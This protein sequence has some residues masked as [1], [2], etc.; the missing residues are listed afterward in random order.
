MRT[1]GYIAKSAES[2]VVGR[3]GDLRVAIL[4]ERGLVT[5]GVEV[6]GGDGAIFWIRWERRGVAEGESIICIIA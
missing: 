4:E 1:V 5:S 3:K 6:A 2:M